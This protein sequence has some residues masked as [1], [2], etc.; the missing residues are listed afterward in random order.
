ML[1]YIVDAVVCQR[2]DSYSRS[3]VINTHIQM[4]SL[5]LAT[6]QLTMTSSVA[7]LMRYK[8]GATPDNKKRGE[9]LG[10]GYGALDH[11]FPFIRMIRVG[12]GL[13][14]G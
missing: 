11:K 12:F 5:L 7:A 9:V 3:L 1:L 6:A 10:E 4:M 13:F 14:W 8:A 2:Q